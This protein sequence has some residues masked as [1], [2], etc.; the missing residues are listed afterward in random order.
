MSQS[1]KTWEK[2]ATIRIFEN[3]PQ[4]KSVIQ[5]EIIKIMK[6]SLLLLVSVLTV[7]SGLNAQ[8]HDRLHCF[9][10]EMYRESIAQDPSILKT[11]EDLEAY[12]RQFVANRKLQRNSGGGT[13][14]VIP[15]VF[16]VLHE[17]G[18]EN[19]SDAQIMDCIMN[20]NRDFRKLN[21]DTINIVPAFQA[22]A[23]DAQIEFRLA[24]IDPN[25]NCTNG[26][27]RIY[28]SKTNSANN[29]SKL[30][31]WPNNMYLNI[32]TAKTLENTGA[33][34][35]AHL[36]GTVS[37]IYDG[38]MSRYDYIGT[39][40]AGSASGVHTI[41]H[42]A[43]HHFNLLH[44]W[45]STNS[46]GVSCGDDFVGDTP[47]TEGWTS[48]NLSGSVCNPPVI[49]NVQNFMEYSYCDCMYTYDQRDRMHATLTS[50]VAGRNNLWTTQNLIATGTQ[51]PTSTSLC[52]PIA[53]FWTTTQSVCEGRSVTFKDYS[54]RGD[55]TQ[56]SWI[57]PGGNPATSTDSMPVVTYNTA[58][59]YD[60]TL[61]ASNAT[62]TDTLVRTGFI[63][64]TTA[65]GNLTP[66]VNSFDQASDFPGTEGWIYNPDVSSTTWTRV[67][68]TGANG[69][70][71]CV[72]INNY[73]NTAGQTDEWIT[74]PY[75]ISNL[76]SARFRFY[77]ANAQRSSTSADLLRVYTSTNCGETWT[78]RYTKQGAT[79]AT[80]GI[81]ATSF[82]PTATEWRLD[83]FNL[84]GLAPRTNVRF[85]FQNISDRG[86][87]TYIDEIQI[88]GTP[89]NVDEVD[90]VTTGFSL[91]P[92]PTSGTT[93]VQFKLNS[94][95]S[96]QV[97]LHDMTGR[98]LKEV[99]NETLNANIHE[100]PITITTPGIYLVDV[101]VGGKH[102]IRRLVV[103]E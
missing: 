57:F 42:E 93:A 30:N 46:P 36:P 39:I 51:N 34:A 6:K 76:T 24:T 84:T 67:T 68:N 89:N 16:H 59:I 98:L 103:S 45:G 48:C 75:D 64:V 33:A 32:W 92:N 12:T 90:E 9:T 86:N 19:I 69:T 71:S 26:I 11:R 21:P 13:L 41:S 27:D 96:V 65:V 73:T 54:W 7:L 23:A 74:P 85:K 50:S 5:A 10:D 63:R 61:I 77:V 14:Y 80:G 100:Y 47:E 87:N 52:A 4:L 55:V 83:T 102:H 29:S 2:S 8:T 70:S 58:G 44:P 43:G 1:A 79:L 53:D 81:R 40:G 49:E 72:R 35:Y 38:I 20:M 17:Y 66:F 78:P 95:Q 56:Y 62:G 99:A 60:V 18:G 37:G 25:G 97:Q 91:F 3:L 31:P 82:T 88:T 28:T 94:T 101:I 15:V 22:L